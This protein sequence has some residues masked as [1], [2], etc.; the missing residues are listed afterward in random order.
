MELLDI[1]IILFC[2]METANIIILYF[3]P[4]FKYG[5]GVSVF[6][7]WEKSKKDENLHLFAKYLVN[8]VAGTKLIF[9]MLLLVIVFLGDTNLKVGANIVM[10]I[11]IATYYLRLNPIIRKLDEKNEIEPKGYSKTLN[12]MITGFI[13]MF[14][15]ILLIHFIK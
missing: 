15:V 4:E 11:S 5:N 14:T 12:M 3:K 2:L 6:K 10:I 9:I 8:W 1:S 13:L 7:H